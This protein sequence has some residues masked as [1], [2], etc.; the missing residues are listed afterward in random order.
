VVVLVVNQGGAVVWA[1][2]LVVLVVLVAPVE[3]KE[4]TEG[5]KSPSRA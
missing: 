5:N 3:M 1:A 2:L 4:A